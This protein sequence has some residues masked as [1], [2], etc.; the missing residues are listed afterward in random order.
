MKYKIEYEFELNYEGDGKTSHQD[1]VD[2]IEEDAV[3]AI[4]EA[5]DDI[6]DGVKMV[7]YKLT[8]LSS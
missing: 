1:I 7:D 4:K 6:V 8:K 2:C 3:I 5:I